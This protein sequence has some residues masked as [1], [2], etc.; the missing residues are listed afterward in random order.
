MWE[1]YSQCFIDS[2]RLYLPR[3]ADQYTMT[4]GSLQQ[5]GENCV[6]PLLK[7]QGGKGCI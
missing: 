3:E 6:W 1:K 4:V 5:D 2:V 7:A